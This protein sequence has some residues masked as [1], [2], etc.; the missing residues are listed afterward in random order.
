MGR[1]SETTHAIG[2]LRDDFFSSCPELQYQ[3]SKSD[4]KKFYMLKQWHFI[5]YCICAEEE[6]FGMVVKAFW[7][8]FL[9]VS[10]IIIL[11]VSRIRRRRVA[12]LQPTEATTTETVMDPKTI[13]G[14]QYKIIRVRWRRAA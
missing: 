7:I 10:L 4:E 14:L 8:L 1:S 2:V 5:L 9:R 6:M 12:Q 13:R 11:R 3:K